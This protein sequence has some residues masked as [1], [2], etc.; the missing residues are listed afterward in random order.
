MKKSSERL[1]QRW[2]KRMSLSLMIGGLCALMFVGCARVAS[3]VPAIVTGW[4]SFDDGSE[5]ETDAPPP[6]EELVP[7]EEVERYDDD[8]DDLLAWALEG[9]S[10]EAGADLG[11][12]LQLRS[13]PVPRPARGASSRFNFDDGRRGWIT[14]LPSAQLLTSPAYGQGK[15]FLGGG[16]ASTRFFA[17]DAF[18]G[19]LSWALRAPDGGPSAAIIKDER[20][21]FNTESCTIFVADAETGEL[22]WSRYLGDPLMSQP[23]ADGEL[24]FSAYPDSRGDGRYYFGAFQLTDGEPRWRVEIP[25]DVIQAPQARDGSVYF[26]TMDGTAFR[27]RQRD[28]RVIWRREIGASS[29]LWVDDSGHVMVSRRVGASH[30]REQML[31]LA[32]ANGRVEN[33]GELFRAPYFEGGTRGHQLTSS[34]PGAWGNARSGERLGLTNVASGWAF[35]GSSPAVDNGRAY[36][37]VGGE[38]RARDMASGETVWRR[39]Y[40]EADRAQAVS[41][42]A[43][44]GSQIIFGT[45][46]GHLYSADIDTGLTLWAYDLGQPIRFQPIVAQ[47]WVYVATAAGDLIGLELGDPA[48]DGWHMWGGNAQHSG[49]VERAGQPDRFLL[50]S[51][52]RPTRGTLRRVAFEEAV[53]EVETATDA[54]TP[55]PEAAAAVAEPPADLP[56]AQTT[57]EAE[58]SGRVAQ[59]VVTQQFQNPHDRPI[60]AVY[61]FPLPQDAAVDDM[62][63]HIGERVIRGEIRRRNQA[64]QIYTEAR[65]EGRRAALLEQ[66]R[67][68]LFAQRVANIQ[69]GEQI[70]VQIRY[71]QMLPFEQGRYEFV[72]PMEAPPRYDPEPPDP[73]APAPDEL[74]PDEAAGEAPAVAAAPPGVASNRQIDLTL[75]LDAG[76]P[77]GAIESP[78]HRLEV[79]RE[80][81]STAT[82]ALASDDRTPDRDLVVRYDVSGPVPRATVLGHRAADGEGY[83][84]LL[85]QPPA[86]PEADAVALRNFTFVVDTSSSMAGR[87]MAQARA[88][89]AEVL[90]GLRPTDTFN[91][92]RF[93]DRVE[94]MSPTPLEGSEANLARGE[95]FLDGLRGAGATEMVPAIDEALRTA[96]AEAEL[97]RAGLQIVVLVTDGFIA[98][99]AEVIRTVVEQMGDARVHGLGVGSSVNRFLLERVAELGRGRSL[100][101]TLSEPPADVA[102]RFVRSVDRPVFTNLEVDWGGLEVSEVYPRRLPDLYASQPLVVHGRYER[103]GSATVRV[104]GSIGGQRYER[105]VEVAL[106]ERPTDSSH[107]V[108][109]TLWARAAVHDRMNRLYLRQDPALIEEVTDIG[110]RHRMM[111]Q[112]TSFVAVDDRP[113]E[114]EEDDIE[115][116][117]RATLSPARSLPGDPEIRIPASRDARAVTVILPFGETVDASWEPALELWCARFLIPRDA[118][119]GVHPVRIIISHAGGRQE[120][121]LLWYTVDSAAPLVEM[122]VVGDV[123]PGA[124][125]TLRAR[126]VVTNADLEQAGLSRAAIERAPQRAQILSDARRVQVAPPSGEV[127]DLGLAGPGVWEAAWTVPTDAGGTLSLLVVVADVAANIRTQSFEVEVLR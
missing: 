106:P 73:T 17:F 33:R 95:A 93:S 1:A 60:E 24:V 117:D 48:F 29:A 118:E 2:P 64:R 67:P 51:L 121:L 68:N 127:V 8:V 4:T 90:A 10:D 100:I 47:G 49:P 116:A 74:A 32:A 56:L 103:G 81:G 45:V 82:V 34:Q 108:H 94:R 9:A 27:L 11:S 7:V 18:T 19:E 110:L 102:G 59:V 122:E 23:A 40:T 14:A 35:Q 36:F 44:V 107:S 63:M 57:V 114:E 15:I 42:P 111:T 125:V 66:Q 25:A 124:V 50:A 22:R 20:V 58:V 65:A 101:A 109:G 79:S 54:A 77:L 55:A 53:G 41:P 6:P 5:A 72:F 69:P 31:V 61:L 104:R 113:A 119:E 3:V 120:R 30:P 12:R 75:R 126:Q 96:A 85:I 80:G 78:T 62:E 21:I 86:A 39:S 26:A 115:V 91:F 70:D 123:E 71:V 37:A 99:E 98:N 97:D 84:S 112:W 83:F 87:P 13:L 43:V 92:M 38:I 76:M 52:E 16:F 105:S 89:M 46:D 28:G 88:V